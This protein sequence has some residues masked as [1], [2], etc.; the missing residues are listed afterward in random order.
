MFSGA[1]TAFLNVNRLYGHRGALSGTNMHPYCITIM[2]VKVQVKR[3]S[4]SSWNTRNTF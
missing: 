2:P 1:K 3:F 4:E